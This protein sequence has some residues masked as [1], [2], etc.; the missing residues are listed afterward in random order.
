MIKTRPQKKTTSQLT[1][2]LDTVFSEF[3][4]LRDADHQGIVTCFVSG[5]RVYYR[6]SDAAHLFVRQHMGTRWD[7]NNVHACTVD[8]NRYDYEHHL[9][10]EAVFVFR[11]GAKEFKRLYDLAHGMQ[12]LTSAE[13]QEMIDKYKAKASELRHTKKI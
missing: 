4:K 9:K 11:Y 10:Y 8:S 3:I 7:E 2:E 5:E 1:K 13:L 6:D 12:K